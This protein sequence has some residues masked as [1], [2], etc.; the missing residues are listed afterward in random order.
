MTCGWVGGKDV[1]L[2]WRW[3]GSSVLWCGSVAAMSP[4]MAA[5]VKEGRYRRSRPAPQPV[6]W[7]EAKRLAVVL[8][9]VRS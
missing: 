7:P 1:E 8:K 2:K 5:T 3:R 4:I 9:S 6:P